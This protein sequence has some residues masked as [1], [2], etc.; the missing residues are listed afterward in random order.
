[1]PEL[2]VGVPIPALGIEILRTM[3]VEP[4]LSSAIYHGKLW[5]GEE[6]LTAGLV[7]ELVE[8]ERL[9][10]RCMELAH[11]LGAAPTAAFA[12]TKGILRLPALDA[13]DRHGARV[14]E[15]N[16]RVW[17]AP[18]TLRAVESY[19]EKTLKKG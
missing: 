2:K 13:L 14:R 17:T 19:I 8:P 11:E 6:C 15:E 9:E 7:H 3:L 5:Q 12:L 4:H 16:L 18:K 1:V 10:A